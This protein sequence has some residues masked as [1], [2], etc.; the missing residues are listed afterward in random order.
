VIVCLSYAQTIRAY[1]N[2]G[3]AYTVAQANIGTRTSLLAAAALALDYLLNVAVAISAGVGALVSAIPSLLPYTLSACLAVLLLLTLVNLRGVR[4]TGLVVLAPT[5]LFVLCLLVMIV[6]GLVDGEPRHVAAHAPAPAG[7]AS[8]W[9]LLGAFAHGCS[10]LTGIEAVSNGVPI[11]RKPSASEARRTLALLG[12]L[13]ATLLVGTALLCRRYGVIA[14]APDSAR[15]ESV[16]SQLASAVFGRGVPYGI[17]IASVVAVLALSANTSFADFPRVCRLLASDRFLPEPFVHRGRRLVF[18]HGIIVLSA[19]SALLLIAFGGVTDRLIPLFALGAL[20]AFTMSQV[21]MV[22]HWR[23]R[24]GK[25]ARLALAMN[26]LG[27]CVTGATLC[28]V[29][30]SKF[31]EG[32]WISIVVIGVLFATFRAVRRHYD[33]VAHATETDA[34]LA[35][36]ALEPPLVVVPL[37]RW[38]AIA[39][40][41]LQFATTISPDVF[42]VQVLTGDRAIDDLTERWPDLTRPAENARLRPPVLVVK[43][44][45]Y[46]RPLD[47][48]LDFVSELVKKHPARAVAVVVPELV[49]PRWYHYLLHGQTAA[50]MKRKLRA[51]GEPRVV[52]INTPWYL[53]D[54]LPERRW[55]RSLASRSHR[56]PS[57]VKRHG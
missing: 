31:T 35:L 45:E 17:T 33:F 51:R 9:L 48:L 52:I 14:T 25:R 3:G 16:L 5:Y 13:L 27:A 53:S 55:L 21:G 15:Y 47:P 10:A 44:T 37:R 43:T 42:V 18:S 1:P 34:T 36:P 23:R 56:L 11:F 22:A 46:R 29:L 26:L 20:L 38:D 49:E 39:V 32:A 7:H 57:L 28:I 19:A 54:W 40:K 24:S 6:L 41:A 12:V 50:V 2:G 8:V 4:S 30:V